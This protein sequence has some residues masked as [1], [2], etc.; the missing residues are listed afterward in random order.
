MGKINGSQ[1]AVNERL[2]A[3]HRVAH[4]NL[5][6]LLNIKWPCPAMC[7]GVV[8]PHQRQSDN[9]EPCPEGIFIIFD[10]WTLS[11]GKWML[12]HFLK[13]CYF[14]YCPKQDLVWY[15]MGAFKNDWF[16]NMSVFYWKK[17]SRVWSCRHNIFALYLYVHWFGNPWWHQVITST[18]VDSSL[19]RSCSMLSMAV[20]HIII[21]KSVTGMCLK[22]VHW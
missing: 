21:Q 22:I 16:K 6:F 3:C 17:Y 1:F 20:P 5:T 18:D 9:S 15:I 4:K 2:N 14:I 7:A 11:W 10:R 12:V 19:V 13:P 8:K